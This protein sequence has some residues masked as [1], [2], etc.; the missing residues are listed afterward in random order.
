MVNELAPEPATE[1]GR[2]RILSTTAGVR[3]SPL[4]LGGMSI[5][6][7]WTELMSSMNKEQSFKLLDAYFEKGG[8]FIDTANEYQDG[9]SE[10]WIGEWMKE[11]GNRDS[12]VLATKFT[13][14][15]RGHDLGLRKTAN[16]SGNH[17]RSLHM[18]LR[19]SLKKLQTEWIDILYLHW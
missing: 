5:G 11:R 14:P 12:I 2:Y 15:Y 7:A 6:D 8:N 16:H 9:R 13:S 3:V 18:S 10:T 4:Q 1:L 19:D 17:K